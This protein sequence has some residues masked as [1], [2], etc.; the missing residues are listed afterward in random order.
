VVGILIMMKYGDLNPTR[1][2]EPQQKGGMTPVVYHAILQGRRSQSLR[3]RQE[4][5]AFHGNHVGCFFFS[6]NA[7]IFISAGTGICSPLATM[8]PKTTPEHTLPKNDEAIT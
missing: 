7:G 4:Y 8:P 1:G 3:L 6:G 2:F 5:S